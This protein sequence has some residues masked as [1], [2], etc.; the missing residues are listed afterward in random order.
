MN[1]LSKLVTVV[2]V[3]FFCYLQFTKLKIRWHASLLHV[4]CFVLFLFFF[5]PIFGL[6]WLCCQRDFYCIGYGKCLWWQCLQ[7]DL[8]R[9]FSQCQKIE[10]T[11]ILLFNY[12]FS[13]N[14]SILI[15][16][17]GLKKI[18]QDL[19]MCNVYRCQMPMF[20]QIGHFI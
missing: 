18:L 7:I 4:C 10:Y 14:L 17:F 1:C 3:L 11:Y 9:W 12:Y 5:S 8:L 2:C 20:S 6:H 13:M 16:R 15:N 19:I